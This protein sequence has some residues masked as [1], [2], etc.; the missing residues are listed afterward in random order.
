MNK[1]QQHR[2]WELV[3]EWL[4]DEWDETSL[5]V[6]LAEDSARTSQGK[7]LEEGRRTSSGLAT[8]R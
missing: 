2:L 4:S 8:D 7:S 5:S 3:A 6:P 1:L